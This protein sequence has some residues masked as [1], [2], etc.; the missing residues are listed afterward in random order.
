VNDLIE[1][2]AQRLSETHV[3]HGEHTPFEVFASAAIAELAACTDAEIAT[4]VDD[5]GAAMFMRVTK[6]REDRTKLLALIS[7]RSAG[8]HVAC[9]ECNGEGHLGPIYANEP[10]SNG[11]RIQVA[12]KVCPRCDAKRY[13]P[14]AEAAR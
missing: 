9:P 4:A 7:A 11:T 13:I 5:F 8:T 14:V 10:R 3:E 12:V 6:G 1:R 2:L